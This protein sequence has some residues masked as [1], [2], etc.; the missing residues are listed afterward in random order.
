MNDEKFFTFFFC[1][2]FFRFI[3]KKKTDIPLLFLCVAI[4][5]V[6]KKERR[7]NKV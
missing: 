3:F 7:T 6:L 5:R 4:F 1:V 2:I